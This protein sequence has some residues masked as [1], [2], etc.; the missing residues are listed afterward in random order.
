VSIT[1]TPDQRNA[2]NAILEWHSSGGRTLTLG[3]YAGTGKTTTLG[4]LRKR[5]PGVRMVYCSYTGKAVSVLKSKLPPGSEVST[6]HRLLYKPFPRMVCKKSGDPLNLVP[7]Y[8]KGVLREG[9][10][11]PWCETHRP[12]RIAREVGPERDL[13][14]VP[15]PPNCEAIRKLDWQQNLMPLEGIDLVVVD[16][17]SMVT[18]KIWEDL[19]KWDVP[20]LAVGDHGQLPPVKSEFN[21]MADPQIRLETI[22]RQVADSP[23][24]RMSIM[25]R[26]GEPIRQGSYGDGVV[27]IP[28][29]KLG[30]VELDPDSPE[31]LIIVGYNRTR[32]D[33]NEMLRRQCGR[34]GSPMV[35]DVVIC[36]RNSYENGVFNGNRGRITG[37]ALDPFRGYT[38]DIEMFG[39]DFTYSGVISE[40]QFGQPKTLSEV[41]RRTGLWDYG[42]AMTCHKAQGSEAD[43]VV[44]IEERMPSATDEY[45]ARWLYTAITRAA[46][47]LT[48]VGA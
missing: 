29:H 6:L 17:A 37:I 28:R 36:L 38:A 32:N 24:I 18:S 47:R 39:E 27:K 21:L 48:L 19:T 5:L 30:R 22:I 41:N 8:A 12:K 14:L 33:T 35:G 44:V 20:C 4:Q 10:R 42:Y 40:Q 16:E 34:R 46:K 26:E 13:Q 23:I 31:Q 11:S 7:D 43:N 9:A 15:M 3:G 25:A 2:L 45:H 1:P